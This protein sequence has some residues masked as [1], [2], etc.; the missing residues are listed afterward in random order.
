LHTNNKAYGKFTMRKNDRI[1]R[2]KQKINMHLF[3]E[4]VKSRWSIVSTSR[5]W[6]RI[7]W[8]LS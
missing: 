1:R 7:F 2:T 5:F 3:L 4:D 6:T 8:I